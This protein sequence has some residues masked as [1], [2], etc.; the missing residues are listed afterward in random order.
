MVEN[1]I[2]VMLAEKRI[3]A[4]ALA[5][6]VPEMNKVG[7]SFI[8]N[9]VTMPTRE[10]MRA[11]CNILGCKATDLYD[12][13]ELDL[14]VT[15]EE[16]LDGQGAKDCAEKLA[17]MARAAGTAAKDLDPTTPV[18]SLEAPVRQRADG[19]GQHEGQRQ[20]RVWLTEEEH[21]ALQKAIKG[22]GYHSAAEWMRE[23]VRNTLHNY[24]A[25]HM[26]HATIQ[27]LLPHS[28]GQTLFGETPPPD[29]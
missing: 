29:M 11:I 14:D 24:A 5:R 28:I 21:N 8:T 15:A 7:M 2:K 23:M 26:K 4:S 16:P 3:S 9:G 25:L 20:F 10:G 22:L 19:W 27:D 18:N 12:K 13:A 6:D 1:K 17:E